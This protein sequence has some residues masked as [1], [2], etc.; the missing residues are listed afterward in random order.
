[1][2]SAVE[3]LQFRLTAEVLEAASVGIQHGVVLATDHEQRRCSDVV[4][5]RAGE[6]DST[7]TGDDRVDVVPT[8]SAMERDVPNAATPGSLLRRLITR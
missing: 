7:A 3:E 4:E 1:V 2:S 6:V 5:A 8:G